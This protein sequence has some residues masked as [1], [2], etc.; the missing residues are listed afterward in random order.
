MF[1]GLV[2]CLGDVVEKRDM[3]GEVRFSVRPRIPFAS[4][5]AGESI[6]VNGA[7]MTAES[8][9]ESVFTAYASAESLA[10]TTL[11]SLLPGS[12][13]NLE[14]AMAMGDRFGGH[15]VSGHVD[16][17]A[18]VATMEKDG[19]STRFR[20]TFPKEFAPQVMPKGSVAL[21]GV[22]LTVNRCGDDFLEVNIIPETIRSTLIASWKPGSNINMETDLVAKHIQRFVQ[23][24]LAGIETWDN[25]P[26]QGAGITEEFLR[27]NGF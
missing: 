1:T 12:A 9:R 15:M 17:V 8:F 10:A 21:D 20:I 5:A 23:C 26:Q 27:E 14:R 11:G 19:L 6:S 16:C 4:P 13:V 3:G 24:R 25:K 18:R 22:S 2:Q 7:C